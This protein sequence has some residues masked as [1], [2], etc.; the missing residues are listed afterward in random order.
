MKF[1]YGTVDNNEVCK[2]YGSLKETFMFTKREYK[3]YKILKSL[4]LSDSETFYVLNENISLEKY[5]SQDVKKI[6]LELKK[7]GYSHE[8]IYKFL[9]QKQH[10]FGYTIKEFLMLIDE[11]SENEKCR[12]NEVIENYL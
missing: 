4:Q 10:L 12:I 11:I 5:L 8:Q 6:I 2:S 9:I 7:Y 3:L 1:F